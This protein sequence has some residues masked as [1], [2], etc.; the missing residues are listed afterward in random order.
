MQVGGGFGIVAYQ[1]MIELFAG[2]ERENAGKNKSLAASLEVFKLHLLS[3]GKTEP[4]RQLKK[5][6]G[7]SILLQQRLQVHNADAN[8]ARAQEKNQLC[9]PRGVVSR[10]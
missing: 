10:I 6:G 4:V 9:K 7:V 1:H 8:I 3:L 5:A 2:I